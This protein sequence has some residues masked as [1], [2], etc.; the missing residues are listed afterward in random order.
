MHHG[1]TGPHEEF[2]NEVTIA[3]AP[4]A[5]LCDRRETKLLGKEVAIDDERVTCERSAAQRRDRHSGDQLA[6]SRKIVAK[7]EG[8][9]QEEMGP[10]D[11]LTPLQEGT[12][13]VRRQSP[14]KTVKMPTCKCV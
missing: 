14:E 10:P 1:Q 13:S 6:Q 3:D 7:R 5:V 11:R 4:Q 12:S 2:D 8:V 9:G